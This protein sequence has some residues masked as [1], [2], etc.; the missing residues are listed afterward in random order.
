MAGARRTPRRHIGL[1]LAGGGPAGAVYEIG[2]LYA[3][4]ECLDGIDFA[5]LSIYVGVSAGAFLAAAL[6]NGVTPS[7]LARTVV[8]S[9]GADSPFSPGTFFK[10][11]LRGWARRGA[12]LPKLFATALGRVAVHP[13]DPSVRESLSRL[14]GGLPVAIF[15]NEPIRRYLARMLSQP[16][17]GRT[18]DFRQLKRKLVVVATDLGSGRAIRF[19]EPGFDHV[20][21]SRAV[22][23]S[24]AFPG[25]YPPVTIDGRQCVDGVLLKTLHAS[26]ALD[27]GA[28]LVFCVNPLVPA[29]ITT[30]IATGALR[31]DALTA[32]GLVTVL[33]QTLRTMIHSRLE[34]GMA[35]YGARYPDSDVVLFEPHPDDYGMF[36]TNIFSFSARGAVC[37]LAYQSTRRTLRQRRAELEPVLARHGIALRA[38]V[39]DDQTRTMSTE[40]APLAP[41]A[42]TSATGATRT[43]RSTLA[44]LAD[45]LRQG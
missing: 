40:G 22:Q 37:E 12:R 5:D 28:K 2:A 1:A 13:G 18:D 42:D 30:G 16:G 10:P 32:G 19:G 44:R 38:D 45:S 26:V 20:P 27:D 7:E 43:L 35:G 25:L 41:P 3:L 9:G 21:I 23:A 31:P 6:A 17:G 11:S 36:F 8:R 14:A 33:S 34:V 29:D 24:S 4:E 39:L 15:E